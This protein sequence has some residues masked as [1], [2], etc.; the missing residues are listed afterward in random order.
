V[1]AF[2][3]AHYG[4]AHMKL[5]AVGDVDSAA[6]QE[7]VGQAFAGWTGGSAALRLIKADKATAPRQAQI[8]LVGK[9]SVSVVLGQ[10][11]GLQHQDPDYQALRMATSILGGSFT[12]RL[13]STVRDKE[14][15][16]Y[17]IDAILD[18][19]AFNEG[20]WKIT[21]SFAPTM[22]DQGIGSTRR[23]LDLWYQEGVTAAEVEF[24]K[25]FLIGAFQVALSTSS[26]MANTFLNTLNRGYPLDWVDEYPA[27]IRALTAQQ[28]NAAI[29]T[30]LQPQN[31]VLVNAG[32][33]TEPKK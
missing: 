12:S 7:G 4:P 6:L 21:A 29:K 25:T 27:K 30:Y 9:T 5:V 24:R 14:G 15:L 1:V 20:D 18:A 28:V 33:L 13:V 16:T 26:G 31:M 23:Q 2:H 8:D 19:D 10:A 17:H 22:L 32:S 11:S 3:K